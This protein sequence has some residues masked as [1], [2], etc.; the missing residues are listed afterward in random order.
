VSDIP[1]TVLVGPQG[2]VVWR[3]TSAIT[4][5]K[6]SSAIDKYAKAG[7]EVAL[8][9]IRLAIGLN[10]RP[11]DVPLRLADGSEL[12]IRRLKGRPIALTFWTSRS[13]PRLDHLEFL[14]D[15][16]MTRG[17]GAPVT[18]A[19]GDGESP[20]RVAEI[21][22]EKG[23]PF[24][25]LPDP[26]RRVSRMFGVWCWP[27]TVWIRPDQRVEAIDFGA[28]PPATPSGKPQPHRY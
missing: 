13:E 22:K 4:A 19:I 2:D 1:A 21:V 15:V 10:E 6:L 14:R 26:N 25:V 7:G 17:R 9:P 24:L 20:E 11:P 16:Q 27:C 12:S 8:H 5:K 18:I 23:F 28:A 3:D